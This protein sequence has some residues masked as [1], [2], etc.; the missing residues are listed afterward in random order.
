ML[1]VFLM[2]GVRLGISAG[3]QTIAGSRDCFRFNA[4]LFVDGFYLCVALAGYSFYLLC[5][6]RCQLLNS[7]V[8]HMLTTPNGVIK[9]SV[10]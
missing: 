5:G 3:L 7:G 9:P 1:L 4:E 8:S 10:S 2:L 6:F